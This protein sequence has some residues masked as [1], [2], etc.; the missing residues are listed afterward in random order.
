MQQ[1]GDFRIDP[2]NECL[3]RGDEMLNLTPRPFAVLRYLVEN[4][5]RLITHDELL[6]AL[7]PETYVQPQV[8]RTYILELRKLLGDD[9]AC[10]RYIQTV[11]K[12]GY[13]FLTAVAD[14]AG[15]GAQSQSSALVGRETE[16][17]FLFEHLKRA[18]KAERSTIFITGEPGIGK[19]A[20]LDTFCTQHCYEEGLRVARGQSLEGFGGK[21]AFYPVREALNDLTSSGDGKVRTLLAAAAPGWLN[22]NG[23]SSLGE[24]CEAL[25]S[26]AAN[27]PLILIFED[28]HWADTSTLDLISALARRRSRTKLMLLASYRPSDIDTEHP[29]R[30]LEQ[31]L[32]TNSRSE[33]LRLGPL[34][35]QAVS[36]YLRRELRSEKLP[37]GLSSLV[38][39]HSAGN[40]LFMTAV[41]DHLCAQNMFRMEDGQLN[42]RVP[43]SEIE[44]GVPEG[45]AGIIE[46][47]LEKL[48]DEDRR[49]LEAGSIAGTIFPAWSAAAALECTIDEVEEAYA[50]LVRR[51]RLLTIAGHDELPDGTQ[52]AFYVFS[53]ALYREVLYTRMPAARRA[54]WHRRVAERLRAMF[55][56]HESNVAHE[57][58]AHAEAGGLVT[59]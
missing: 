3:W 26:L 11:P 18:K 59:R 46:F 45:L 27:H 25:E 38:H 14:V 55:A 19:T 37:S 53:H 28:I 30:L 57:I 39:Q 31:D 56:G 50:R 34:N 2:Q 33:E 16:L 24:L 47:Q 1:F 12:R 43:L 21:E 40:P 48:T 15:N 22:G 36:E 17:E 52:S 20:L 35:K 29:L 7:W 9:P 54:Q 51:V 42:L 58:A 32:L 5:Q 10:P 44:L 23:S 4:P 13:R 41:L 8:L 6:E 49:L